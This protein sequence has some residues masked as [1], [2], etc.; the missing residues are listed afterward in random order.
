MSLLMDALRKAEEAKKRAEL[1]SKSVPAPKKHPPQRDDAGLDIEIEF[2]APAENPSVP[3][4][5]AEDS[6]EPRHPDAASDFALQAD[7]PDSQPEQWP[8]PDANENSDHAHEAAAEPLDL[9][10]Q[11]D[12]APAPMFSGTDSGQETEAGPDELVEYDPDPIEP[13]SAEQ[14]DSQEADVSAASV[15]DVVD[16][17]AVDFAPPA[18]N[19]GLTDNAPA[20]PDT[21][22]SIADADTAAAETAPEPQAETVAFVAPTMNVRAE[23]PV[24]TQIPVLESGRADTAKEIGESVD[25]DMEEQDRR[26]AQSVFSAKRHSPLQKNL[27]LT[28]FSV[29]AVLVVAIGI[30]FYINLQTS[31]GITISN[32]DF[33]YQQAQRD[34]A[35]ADFQQA[36]VDGTLAS[37]FSGIDADANAEIV[38]DVDS[39]PATADVAIT[40]TPV[41][42]APA[43]TEP[44]N[45][46][47]A[48][49][50]AANL[51]PSTIGSSNAGLAASDDSLSDN[52]AAVA[53][54]VEEPV[55]AATALQEPATAASAAVSQS[56]ALAPQPAVA[57]ASA[58]TTTASVGQADASS[59]SGL[60][61]SPQGIAAGALQPEQIEPPALINFSR[62]VT[63]PSRNPALENAYAAYQAGDF[64]VAERLYSEVLVT[65]PLNRNA[66]LGLASIAANRRD[67]VAALELYSKLLA[68]NPNDPVAQAGLLDIMPRGSLREQETELKRLRAEN[69]QMAPL[70]YALGNFMASQQRWSE[71]QQA[72]FSALQLAKNDAQGGAVNPDYAFNLAVSLEH[73]GQP[74]PASNYYQEALALAEDHP[75]GFDPAV[76]RQR[77]SSVESARNE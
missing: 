36:D 18:R 70:A 58:T 44:R 57:D 68:R 24:S 25:T 35:N 62:S 22:E 69:P 13:L 51:Q 50:S 67:T 42:T 9:P 4:E 59:N 8:D 74:R 77:L 63:S 43:I 5:R 55:A 38:Q 30:Y 41:V 46:E 28:A 73:L 52:S 32:V 60:N 64:D 53:V 1:K 26:S 2:D 17:N 72:Y 49:Q 3:A 45:V 61:S 56:V 33:D 34:A 75:A 14:T 76:A 23:E 40:T 66:L 19:Q 16:D 20:M 11:S 27:Q 15:S 6:V 29:A 48:N 71:A 12:E 37:D 10:P 47:L 54:A 7:D 65:A 31:S 21:E 39:P